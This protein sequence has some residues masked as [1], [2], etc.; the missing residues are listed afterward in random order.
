MTDEALKSRDE[1]NRTSSPMGRAFFT[2]IAA[3]GQLERELIVERVKLGLKNAK[4]KG[5]IL[6]R[7]K[8][9]P[10]ELIR[11]LLRSGMTFRAAAKVA[12]CSQG[13]I[14]SEKRVM[15]KE[16]AEQLELKNVKEQAENQ[17]APEGAETAVTW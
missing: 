3:I 6:G 15:K 17:M 2:V 14:S 9:R 13:A 11:A 10:S 5:K 1:N 7:K 8:T 12:G 16:E 4:A